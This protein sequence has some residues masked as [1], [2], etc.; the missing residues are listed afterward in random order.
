MKAEDLIKELKKLSPDTEVYLWAPKDDG[1]LIK[2][3]K[4][5]ESTRADDKKYAIME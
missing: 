5:R 4:L 3:F 1:N 2:D